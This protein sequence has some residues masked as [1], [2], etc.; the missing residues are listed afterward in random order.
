LGIYIS[1]L[2]RLQE[3]P[4]RKNL[5]SGKKPTIKLAFLPIKLYNFLK[6]GADICQSLTHG[7]VKDLQPLSYRF[8]PCLTF[9]K[10]K[11]TGMEP[12]ISPNHEAL[13]NLAVFSVDEEFC[14]KFGGKVFGYTGAST[15]A[16]RQLCL[17]FSFLLERMARS[18]MVLKSRIPALEESLG[19]DLES[20]LRS[21]LENGR[22]DHLGACPLWPCPLPSRRHYAKCKSVSVPTI[23]TPQRQLSRSSAS[24]T[25][26]FIMVRNNRQRGFKNA[27]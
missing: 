14:Q 15:P 16:Y 1:S 3:I 2:F 7:I 23:F 12:G 13:K 27:L 22:E 10:A 18:L 5:F 24:M 8:P 9:L 26:T 19:N 25:K 4:S 20:H 11:D 6:V 21:S 17:D